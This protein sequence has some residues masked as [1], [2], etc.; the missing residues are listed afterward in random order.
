[1]HWQIS[2][3][4][5]TIFFAFATYVQHNDVDSVLWITIY[6]VPCLIS[7]F[8][9]IL[10]AINKYYFYHIIIRLLLVIYILLTTTFLQ[11]FVINS[12]IIDNYNPLHSEEGREF[13]GLIIIVIWISISIYYMSAE[14][15]T[16]VIVSKKIKLSVI[17]FS[18]APV[19]VWI[20]H[21]LHEMELC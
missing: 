18:I 17:G 19:L 6:S 1:M 12:N 21:I 16:D 5:M 2:N 14:L 13:L 4:I 15:P 3:M 9:V 7:L 10:P 8:Q 20:Y 11:E